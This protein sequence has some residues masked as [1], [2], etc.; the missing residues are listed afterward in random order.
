MGTVPP[1]SRPPPWTFG[2]LG[3]TPHEAERF[4]YGSN[5]ERNAG[6]LFIIW[7]LI[8]PPGAGTSMLARR[9]TTLLP[10]MTRAEALEATRVDPVAGP[11]RRALSG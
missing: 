6:V 1:A 7:L 2:G 9:L 8:G 4:Q 10:A 3:G 5:S 11:Q